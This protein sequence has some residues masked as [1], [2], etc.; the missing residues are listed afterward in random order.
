[1]VE[2]GEM[3]PGQPVTFFGPFASS[4]AALTFMRSLTDSYGASAHMVY[5][6]PEVP[7]D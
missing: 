1:M 4:E 5:P 6:V 2:T 7:H 3:E